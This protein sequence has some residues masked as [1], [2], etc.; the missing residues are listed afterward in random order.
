M[1]SSSLRNLPSFLDRPALLIRVFHPH[2]KPI[3]ER[4]RLMFFG[5]FHQD[6]TEFVLA[7]LGIYNYETIPVQSAPFR[8]R[9]HV[10][11]FHQLYRCQRDLEEGAELAQLAAAIPPPIADSDWLEDVRQRLLFQVAAA[12]ER[13]DDAPSALTLAQF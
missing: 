10:K 5:N 9:E 11:A 3:A 12:H 8:T 7:D 4:F 2:V 6:W 13:M 1:N